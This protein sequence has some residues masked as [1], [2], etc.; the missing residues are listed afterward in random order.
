MKNLSNLGTSLSKAEQRS[1]TGGFIHADCEAA[2]DPC[3]KYYRD[4]NGVLIIEEGV[5][6]ASM[7]CIFP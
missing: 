4:S 5:C 7:Q 1:I 2:G 6:N 3:F